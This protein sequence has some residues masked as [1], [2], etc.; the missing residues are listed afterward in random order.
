MSIGIDLWFYLRTTSFGSLSVRSPRNTGLPKLIV[1]SPLGELDLDDQ[2]R[3]FRLIVNEVRA[4]EP[5]QPLPKLQVTRA[6]WECLPDFKTACAAWIYAG[7]AHHTGFSYAV[8]TEHLED[9]AGI[10]GVEL[11]LIDARTELRDFKRQLREGEMRLSFQR[12]A[13]CHKIIELNSFHI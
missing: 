11:T 3:F 4:I 2:H 5:P 6:L 1:V 12:S 8:T 10:A 7:G 13:F 9:L